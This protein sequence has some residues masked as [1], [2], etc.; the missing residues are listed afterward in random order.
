MA[1][2]WE[3]TVA[4]YG[5]F[6]EYPQLT[7]KYLR[8]PPFKYLFQIFLT[9][10]SKTGFAREAFKEAD[11]NPDFY[12][13]PEKKMAF[14]K[15]IIKMVY[16][17]LGK[18]APLKPQSVIKGTECEQTNEFLQ[19]MFQAAVGFKDAHSSKETQA[20]PQPPVKEA[21]REQPKEASKPAQMVAAAEAPRQEK[22]QP[23]KETPAPA[24]AKPAAQTKENGGEKPKGEPPAKTVQAV[25][26]A[27][28]REERVAAKPRIGSGNQSEGIRMGK[29]TAKPSERQT[30]GE[31]GETDTKEL[32]S[33]EIKAVLQ[34]LTQQTNP[35]G[36]LVEFVEDDLE[37]MHRECQRWVR[38]FTETQEKL[39]RAEE[40]QT[41]ELA[42]ASQT[43]ADLGE[44]IFDY[45]ARVQSVRSRI[46]RNNAKI[47]QMLARVIG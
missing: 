38:A 12:D 22:V 21:A 32:T 25:V 23:K 27:A 5:G 15:Q 2:F 13:T 44:Q 37:A 39:Q 41:A 16:D 10:N 35:L 43:L 1:Q 45:E 18:P 9:L 29:L 6:V 14:L 47:D 33:E 24:P 42:A 11:L 26:E 19:D 3:K 31:T 17:A 40:E 36:K 30:S 46:Q 7:E 28:A 8:R 20:P 34:K 4:V